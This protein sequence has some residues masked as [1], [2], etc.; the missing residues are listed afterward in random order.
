MSN[1]EE[2]PERQESDPP[3]EF[4]RS[5]RRGFYLRLGLPSLVATTGPVVTTWVERPEKMTKP[6]SAES[7]DA[8]PVTLTVNGKKHDLRIDPRTTL[9]DCFRETSASHRH[10]KGLRSRP[11]RRLHGACERPARELRVSASPLMHD[12]DEITTIEGLGTAGGTASDAGGVRCLRRLPVRLLHVRADHVG[13]G[14]AQGT[15][16]PGRRGREGI[17]E[18]QHLPLR[19]LSEHRR[20]DPASVARTLSRE[21]ERS[22]ENLRIHSARRCR[23]SDRDGRAGEDRAAGRGRA[24]HRRR[25]DADRSD[26]A[27]RRDARSG[28]STSTACRSTRSKRRPTAG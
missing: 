1:Q 27:E 14:A 20:R 13:G 18:R 16:R 2:I 4:G 22:D 12:G 10:E 5:T 9:L 15:V 8:I 21:Q 3:S 17:D 23:G 25:H 6:I 19:R 26:E 11:V 28:W 7:K 24:L